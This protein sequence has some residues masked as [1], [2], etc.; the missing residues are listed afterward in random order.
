MGSSTTFLLY[1]SLHSL[2]VYSLAKR[3]QLTLEISPPLLEYIKA[4]QV[5]RAMYDFQ[6]QLFFSYFLKIINCVPCERV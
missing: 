4:P 1:Y 5:A 3:P 2:S 6:K